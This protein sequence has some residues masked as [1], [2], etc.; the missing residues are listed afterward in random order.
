MMWKFLT[1]KQSPPKESSELLNLTDQQQKVIDSKAA[2]LRVIARAGTGKTSTMIAKAKAIAAQDLSHRILMLSFTKSAAEELNER[3]HKE[4][5]DHGS[6]QFQASTFH[7]YAF[8]CLKNYPGKVLKLEEGLLLE[9]N[10]FDLLNEFQREDFLD[11]FGKTQCPDEGFPADW[12]DT[13]SKNINAYDAESC[14]LAQIMKDYQ[15][16]NE[17]WPKLLPFY[18]KHG[19]L[20]FDLIML[21][22]NRALELDQGFLKH[23]QANFTHLIIDEFQDTNAVQLASLRKLSGW[24]SNCKEK[25]FKQVVVVGDDF[26]TLYSWRGASRYIFSDFKSWAD[27]QREDCQTLPLTVNFRSGKAILDFLNPHYK[28]LQSSSAMAAICPETI[29]CAR[30][31]IEASVKRL[32]SYQEAVAS[33]GKLGYKNEEIT[34]LAFKNSTL[35]GVKK[36]YRDKAT[37]NS[38]DLKQFPG[39]QNFIAALSLSFTRN[40]DHLPSAWHLRACDDA[41]FSKLFDKL[42]QNNPEKKLHSEIFKSYAKIIVKQ[43]KLYS[44][45][46]PSYKELSSFLKALAR[47]DEAIKK[48]L[49]LCKKLS[50]VLAK[51]PSFKSS[52]QVSLAEI[53]GKDFSDNGLEEGK[54]RLSTIHKFKGLQSRAIILIQDFQIDSIE[55]KRLLYVALTRPEQALYIVRK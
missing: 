12:R 24:K 53:S 18:L 31:D 25:P 38:L 26:Q 15:I 36:Y 23:A 48:N 51:S 6:L 16:Y 35:R 33:L 55:K 49:G 28:D 5:A 13:L 37:V 32:P 22:F 42:Q 17:L 1:N 27:D 45:N 46:P 43:Q 34:I 19:Y 54:I 8:H 3:F 30:I 10:R 14:S 29:S 50:Y 21:I 41:E 44:K 2:L 11:Y 20:D 7:S 9:T 47:Q 4:E 52:P 39:L 40:F